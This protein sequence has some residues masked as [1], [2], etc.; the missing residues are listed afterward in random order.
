MSTI[1]QA[2]SS[3]GH[4]SSEYPMTPT[5]LTVLNMRTYKKIQKFQPAFV[6]QFEFFKFNKKK[7]EME[8]N[9]P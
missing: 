1:F 3:I 9:T 5:A 8:M 2:M 7:P 6:G 4:C